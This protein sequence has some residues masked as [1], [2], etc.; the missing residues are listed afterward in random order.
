[1]AR[2][3]IFIL[4]R[5]FSFQEMRE[6]GE[7]ER[8]TAEVCSHCHYQIDV[9][10]DHFL[11]LSLEVC[12]TPCSSK[13]FPCLDAQE[14]NVAR[15]PGGMMFLPFYPSLLPAHHLHVHL[16]G[17]PGYTLLRIAFQDALASSA[18]K[19]CIKLRIL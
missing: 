14:M 3:G 9:G 10:D 6:P 1:M 17:L 2:E 12:T 16:V 19:D 4:H 8:T 5:M 7:A 18:R 13:R 11:C 15:N